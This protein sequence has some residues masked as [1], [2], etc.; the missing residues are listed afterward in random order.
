MMNGFYLIFLIDLLTLFIINP[1]QGI[2][3]IENYFTTII[4][5]LRAIQVYKTD[6]FNPDV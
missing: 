6:W 2:F 3:K 5:A 1:L 4:N